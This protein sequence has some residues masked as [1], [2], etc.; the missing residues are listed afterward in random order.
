[1][2]KLEA[3]SCLTELQGFYGSLPENQAVKYVEILARRPSPVIRS[4][5]DKAIEGW[6]G[7]GFPSLGFLCKTAD[8]LRGDMPQ[9]AQ[10]AGDFYKA[11][12]EKYLEC[13]RDAEAYAANWLKTAPLAQQAR[14]EG[15]EYDLQQYLVEVAECQLRHVRKL[16]NG[17]DFS[18]VLPGKRIG[19]PEARVWVDQM[20][21]DCAAYAP[22]VE[23]P[24]E[25]VRYW[26]QAAQ[27]RREHAEM[28]GARKSFKQDFVKK[29]VL[30]YAI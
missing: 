25:C 29:P 13:R 5:A 27:K 17:V 19:E 9:A 14:A 28:Y 12:R 1:M 21:Q 15:W 26:Q 6:T 4:L 2:S 11:L 24:A 10:A 23:V 30:D 7:R 8:S 16:N 3:V 22:N 20:I 18:R